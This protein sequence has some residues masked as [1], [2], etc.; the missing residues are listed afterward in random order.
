M[1]RAIVA[2]P[3]LLC[4]LLCWPGAARAE[5]F[6][7]GGQVGGQYFDLDAINGG[8]VFDQALEQTTARL[9]DHLDAHPELREQERQTGLSGLVT[10]AAARAVAFKR[11]AAHLVKGSRGLRAYMRQKFPGLDLAEAEHAVSLFQRA[12][13]GFDDIRVSAFPGTSSCFLITQ[14]GS[15][16]HPR[17]WT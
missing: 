1:K 16:D 9:L 11:S 14:A 6:Y 17:P 4:A 3:F 10:R 8:Q 5:W 12:T 7:L 15:R 2:T 13:G